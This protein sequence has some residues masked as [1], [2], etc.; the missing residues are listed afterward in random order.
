[1]NAI[2][3]IHIFSLARILDVSIPSNWMLPGGASHWR[4]ESSIRLDRVNCWSE[5]ATGPVVLGRLKFDQ[6]VLAQTFS[7]IQKNCSSLEVPTENVQNA[8]ETALVLLAMPRRICSKDIRKIL[9]W[10]SFN[11]NGFNSKSFN[12][13]CHPPNEWLK[14]RLNNSDRRSHRSVNAQLLNSHQTLNLFS[15]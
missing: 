14:L 8:Q 9:I 4:F 7:N 1:M 2:H 11:S 10:K 5:V 12:S 13:F 15:F 3:R 6:T